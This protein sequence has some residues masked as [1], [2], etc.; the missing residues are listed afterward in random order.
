[1]LIIYRILINLILILSPI[2]FIYRLLK[3]KESL[4]SYKQK[5][6]FFFKGKNKKKLIWFHGASVG[7]LKS[8]VP[9]LEKFEKNNKVNQIL[10]T[11][12]TLSSFKIIKNLKLKKT[13]H[14]FFPIDSNF[15][16][17]KFINHWKPQKVY[18]I[19]SEIWPNMLLNLKQNKIPVALING[20]ITKK[21]FR[22]WRLFSNSASELFSQIDV[23]LPSSLTSFR[24]LKKLNVKKLRLIGNLKFSQSELELPF[25]DKKLKY[26]LNK[27]KTWCASS[28][29]NSEELLSGIVHLKLKKKIN[30]LLTIIIPRHIERCEKIKK[31]LEKLNLKVHMDQPRKKISLDTDIYLV[32]S[33]G[34]TNVFFDNTNNVFLGGSLIN[35]GGQN[36]L[37]AARLGC[38][39]LNGPNTQNFDEIYK[40]LEKNNISQR[41]VN[42]FDL[43]SKLY[44]LL[45]KKNKSKKVKNK[46]K[47]I[48]QNILEKT[49]KEINLI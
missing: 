6:G 45:N 32:N 13:F 23:C 26:F 49:Y 18:F 46:I 11:S 20:R 31:N 28:T 3:K 24:Y 39:I 12:N 7:E 10:I 30:N 27:K 2:I 15:I 41:V 16:T 35:H 25:I 34:K 38:N 36:P 40:F 8:I 21:T 29:H 5:I 9:L 44:T 17:K 33:Y 4:E 37:E 14:Q 47:K 42:Q 22:R 1:M 43:A 19:D 48:G